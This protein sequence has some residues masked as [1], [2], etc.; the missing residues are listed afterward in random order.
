MGLR[1][2]LFYF[3]DITYHSLYV[4]LFIPLFLDGTEDWNENLAL[5]G[6]K[7]SLFSHFSRLVDWNASRAVCLKQAGCETV[8][9]IFLLVYVYL[10]TCSISNPKAVWN[11]YPYSLCFVCIGY[12]QDS[13]IGTL[14]WQ[15]FFWEHLNPLL[16][17]YNL[18]IHHYLWNWVTEAVM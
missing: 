9:I 10:W 14:A 4:L 16:S 8:C 1:L 3:N 2:L 18:T 5:F 12:M 17:P 11:T 6:I 13:L 15:M 7:G